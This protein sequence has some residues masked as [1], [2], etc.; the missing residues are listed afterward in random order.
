MK[1]VKGVVYVLIHFISICFAPRFA[2]RRPQ[3]RFVEKFFRDKLSPF[4][5]KWK[6]PLVVGGLTLGGFMGV[7]AADLKRPT[8]EEFQL[9]KTGHPME[10]YDLVFKKMF[11]NGIPD[12][13]ASSSSPTSIP[14]MNV[15]F[16]FGLENEDNGNH[17]DPDDFGTLQF[18]SGFTISDTLAQSFLLDFE[19]K[20]KQLDLWVDECTINPINPFC[21]LYNTLNFPVTAFKHYVTTPCDAINNA[22][23]TPVSVP[24]ESTAVIYFNFRQN[25]N[26]MTNCC[27]LEFP[28]T[29]PITFQ[30]CLEEYS[31]NV[32]K[33]THKRGISI[34]N[35]NTQQGFWFS[36]DG[37]EL[38]GE[39]ASL[40]E[41][42][43]RVTTEL[44]VFIIPP[45]AGASRTNQS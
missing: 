27:S 23:A 8:T 42:E 16:V 36:V 5:V 12:F 35:D 39:R 6:T 24:V 1:T 44:N 11:L 37:G 28:V 9:F 43:K 21:E 4:V 32:G 45:I 25:P 20:V 40:L 19:E 29:N 30:N 34:D 13:E 17:W 10:N 22:T 3:L 38:R 41:D 33:K 14:T 26:L 31:H 7:K 2:R 15:N 18:S